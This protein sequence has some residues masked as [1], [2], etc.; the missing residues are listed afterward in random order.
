M[1]SPAIGLALGALTILGVGCS[2]APPQSASTATS[3]LVHARLNSG[4]VVSPTTGQHAPVP[5]GLNNARG[6]F[7]GELD[8][9]SKEL[10]WHLTYSGLGTP[11]VVIADVHYGKVG[12]FGALLVRLCAPCRTV[13]PSGMVTVSASARAALLSGASWVTLLTTSYPNGAIRGQIAA[14]PTTS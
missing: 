12:Q 13:H 8:M 2:S 6:T 14:A 9:A 10:S 11:S 1:R 7:A 3:R 4:Q 5:P